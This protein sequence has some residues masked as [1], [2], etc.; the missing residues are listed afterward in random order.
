M[1]LSTTTSRNTRWVDT[2]D[3]RDPSVPILSTNV[4]N[5]G[6][7]CCWD[8]SGGLSVKTPTDQADMAY[9]MGVADIQNPVSSGIDANA[10]QLGIYYSMVV[11]R[12]GVLLFYATSG[13]TYTPF[14][15]VYF[16]ETVSVQTVTSSTNSGAR[17][18]AVGYYFPTGQQIVRGGSSNLDVTAV[19]GTIIPVWITP[20][21]P[22]NPNSVAPVV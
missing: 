8:H 11:K 2:F 9:Y 14:T 18:V 20:I 13:E 21:Y 7:L 15:V 22:A 6:D 3:G 19:S 16:N 12:S 17:T 5:A 10:E 4:M 1:A